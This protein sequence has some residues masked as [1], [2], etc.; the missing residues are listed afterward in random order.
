MACHVHM[1]RSNARNQGRQCQTVSTRTK[2]TEKEGEAIFFICGNQLRKLAF[3]LSFR[4]QMN[5][6]KGWP[7]RNIL[8]LSLL[9]LHCGG[10]AAPP[11][12][13][14]DLDY[15]TN[16]PGRHPTSKEQCSCCACTNHTLNSRL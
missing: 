7:Y 2:D 14:S 3:F 5:C 6:H 11:H 12:I 15:S 8:I 10:A 16:N 13:I 1:R 4:R 9:I